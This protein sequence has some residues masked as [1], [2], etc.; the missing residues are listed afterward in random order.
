MKK[1]VLF[2]VPLPPPIHGSAMVSQYIKDGRLIRESFDCDFVNLST[3]RRMDEIGKRNP[4]KLLRFALSYFA[5][6]WKLLT[7]R[8]DLCYLAITCHGRGFLKDAPFV[9]LCKLFRRKV[10]IHQHNKGMAH[11]V[12]RWPY[13]WLLPWVYKSTKVILLSWR[14]Y[15]DIEKVVPRENV[16]VCPNGIPPVSYKYRTRNNTTPRLLFLSNLMVSKGVLVL[17]DALKNLHDKG[18]N[19]YC[20]FIGGATQEIGVDRFI[21]E[22]EKRGLVKMVKY[23]GVK[24]GIEKASFFEKAD[25]FVHPTTDDCFPLVLVEAMQYGLPIVTTDEGGIPDI[26]EDGVNGLV[27]RRQDP[28]SLADCIE[29]I[30]IDAEL[31]LQMGQNGLHKFNSCF[32][33]DCFERNFVEIMGK[34]CTGSLSYQTD[35]NNNHS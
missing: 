17:L 23:H 5:T 20:D 1:Q 34:T 19:I 33:I 35:S 21:K 30:V 18:Y 11:D 13:R 26:V 6:F 10:I 32:T 29:K 12:N 2:V 22:V 25:L 24:T 3:S 4:V 31:R 9:L 27:A 28:E 15:P 7:R 16:A 8:Y 14:L